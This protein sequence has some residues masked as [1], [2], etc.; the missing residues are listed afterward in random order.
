MKELCMTT[1]K[2]ELRETDPDLTEPFGRLDL[3]L[4]LR[5]LRRPVRDKAPSNQAPTE[6]VQEPL[7]ASTDTDA[8]ELED[9][10]FGDR[11]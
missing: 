6:P 5:Y 4:P 10:F 8:V 7:P 11:L 2:T 3:P 1:Q 9:P